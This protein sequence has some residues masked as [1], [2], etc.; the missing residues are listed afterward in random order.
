[1]SLYESLMVAV[2]CLSVVFSVL[3]VLFLIIRLFSFLVG[4]LTTNNNLEEKSSF[5]SN[6][7]LINE[8]NQNSTIGS[9]KLINVDE[10]T[11]AMIMAI[12][13]DETEIPL[14]ELYFKSIR[15]IDEV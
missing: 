13:S 7:E 2:I 3:L 14:P 11:A 4:F 5:K 8:K 9:L 6:V 1:M 15:L 10:P 12:V